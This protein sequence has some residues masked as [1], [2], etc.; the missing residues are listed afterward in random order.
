[1]A[2]RREQRYACTWLSQGIGDRLVKGCPW[3]GERDINSLLDHSSWRT[4]EVAVVLGPCSLKVK[5]GIARLLI[6]SD[7]Q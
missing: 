1:M 6:N 5:H 3:V 2:V 7:F 4:V